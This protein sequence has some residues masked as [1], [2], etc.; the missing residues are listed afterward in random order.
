MLTEDQVV[1]VTRHW[2]ERQGWEIKSYCHGT[3][4]GDDILAVSPDGN[5]LS[6]ECKGAISPRTTQPFL[7]NYIW[8]SISGALFNT[9]RCIEEA[10]PTK[11]Y[12]MAFPDKMEFREL[13]KSLRE[14][15]KRNNVY[16]FWVLPDG[17]SEVWQPNPLLNLAPSVAGRR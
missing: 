10:D 15:Y 4:K 17:I 1:D 5:I 7:G 16:M 6:V 3:A 14:F 12:A 11:R 8:K 2:L 9:I 13:T